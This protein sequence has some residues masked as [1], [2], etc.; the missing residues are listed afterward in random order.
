MIGTIN[1][2]GEYYYMYITIILIA[3]TL[4]EGAEPTALPQGGKVQRNSMV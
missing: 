2:L 3:G 4:V 1:S